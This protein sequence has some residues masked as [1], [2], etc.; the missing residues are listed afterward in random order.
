MPAPTTPILDNFVG[1]AE[2]LPVRSPTHWATTTS[3]TSVN[4]ETDGLGNV[5][6]HFAAGAAMNHW[7]PQFAADQEVYNTVTDFPSITSSADVLLARLTTPLSP[8]A[9]DRY[10]GNWTYV[11]GGGD[12]TFTILKV[13]ATVATT[14]DTNSNVGGAQNIVLGNKLWFSCIGPLIRFYRWDGAVWNL[15]NSAVDTDLTGAGHIA[16]Y[17]GNPNLMTTDFG[18][19]SVGG[20]PTIPGPTALGG[21]F[22]M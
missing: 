21:R 4:L 19:G 13:V 3:I 11:S 2:E 14:L 20:G 15:L 5:R 6:T 9:P 18:G 1:A 10:Q 7:L 17:H 8:T 16:V 12:H 22:H